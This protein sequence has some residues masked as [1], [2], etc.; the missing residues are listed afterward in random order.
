MTGKSVSKSRPRG[1]ELWLCCVAIVGVALSSASA[2]AAS[3]TAPGAPHVNSVKASGKRTITVAFGKPGTDGGAPISIYRA[4][5][6]S[7]DGGIAGANDSLRSPIR[8][9]SLSAGRTYTC[10]VRARN[11]VGEGPASKP[12][13]PVIVRPKPPAAPTITSVKPTGLRAVLVTFSKP[14]DDGGAPISRYQA[15][16][17]SSTGGVAR[18][19]QGPR[20]PIRVGGLSASDT[21]TCTVAAGNAIGLGSA[22]EQ[23]S[24]V[25]PRPVAPGPP[26]LTS[27]KATG[28]RSVTVAFDPPADNGGAAITNYLVRCASTDGGAKRSRL[29]HPS[30]IRVNGLTAAKTYRC[31]VAA[32]NNV[33]LGKA[34]ALSKPF[35]V[36]SN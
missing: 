29:A 28:R 7:S 33:A 20:S 1:L 11:R 22:S 32:S 4:L 12:S 30:P 14:S 17:A 26:T 31:T 16:C 10:T 9:A 3:A 2:G 19:Q 25:V 13:D 5:C 34:S 27:A 8:V 35:V 15:A 18:V 24:P 21:Y 36:R 6:T 23:S